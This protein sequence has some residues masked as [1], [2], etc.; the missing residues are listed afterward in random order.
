VATTIRRASL[1]DAETLAALI[2]DSFRGVAERFHLTPTN[3]PTHPSNCE[4]EWIQRDLDRGVRY[5]LL[6]SNGSTVGCIALE[7]PVGSLAYLERLAVLP[8]QR[9]NG[10]GSKL[11]RHAVR[12]ARLTGAT[13]ASVGII[14]EHSELVSWYEKL[15]FAH[16]STQGFPHLPFKV[17]YLEQSLMTQHVL[18]EPGA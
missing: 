3:A 17:S 12:E 10:F 18:R 1:A 11:V 9:G 5:Y 14:A 4:P 8:E 7:L 2:R 13:T 6:A 15:G 16:V